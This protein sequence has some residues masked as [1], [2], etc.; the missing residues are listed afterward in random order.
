MDRFINDLEFETIIMVSPWREIIH[1]ASLALPHLSSLLKIN[2]VVRFPW[3][4]D[5]HF[6]AI[7]HETGI[8]SLHCYMKSV[9]FH[10][11]PIGSRKLSI[12]LIYEQLV[13]Q[14]KLPSDIFMFTRE[15]NRKNHEKFIRILLHSQQYLRI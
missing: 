1:Q 8:R 6:R 4:P 13:F 7:W 14:T 5:Y 2:K 3:I 10:V 15:D 9:I 12:F 11:D